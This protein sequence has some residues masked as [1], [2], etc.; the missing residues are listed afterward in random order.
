[1]WWFCRGAAG[2][3]EHPEERGAASPH[4]EDKEGGADK[5]E[6]RKERKKRMVTVSLLDLSSYFPCKVY[7][8]IIC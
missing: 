8:I 4:G 1:M 5:M 3:V 7:L 2:A 6:K